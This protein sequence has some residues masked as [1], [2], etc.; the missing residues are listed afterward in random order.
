VRWL[1]AHQSTVAQ[2]SLAWVIRHAAVVAIPGAFTVEQL[3]SNAAAADI[4]LAEDECQAL[5][6]LSAGFQSIDESHSSRLNFREIKHLTRAGYFLARTVWQ[7]RKARQ[8]PE[9]GLT[10]LL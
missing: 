3:E 7:D 1:R 9:R 8:R 5:R 10:P 2:I 6:A 4:D